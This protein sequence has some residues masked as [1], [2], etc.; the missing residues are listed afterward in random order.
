[1]PLIH[2]LGGAQPVEWVLVDLHVDEVGLLGIRRVQLLHRLELGRARGARTQRRRREQQHQRLLPGRERIR[3]GH[4]VHRARRRIAADVR[5]VAV[6]VAIR[7]RHRSHGR[8]VVARCAEPRAHLE[9]HPR[10][11][12]RAIARVER[13]LGAPLPRVGE[14]DRRHPDAFAG[15]TDTA[16]NRR[17]ISTLFGLPIRQEL[18]ELD[19][20]IARGDR[21]IASIEQPERE[22]IAPL[23][24]FGA[25]LHRGQVG[26]RGAR[27][28]ERIGSSWGGRRRLLAGGRWCLAGGE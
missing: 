18:E 5:G 12:W 4:R 16:E 23:G 3:D 21:L 26:A 8:L 22:A 15:S 11:L 20:H 24:Q 27:L 17:G 9:V 19:V 28:D 10:R 25:G 1:M 7:R 2:R 14:R 6:D 13:H